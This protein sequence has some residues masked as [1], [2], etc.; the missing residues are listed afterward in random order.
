MSELPVLNTAD[1]PSSSTFWENK[2]QTQATGWDLGNISPP[3]KSFINTLENKNVAILIPGCGNAYEAEYL[4]QKGFT[5]ITLIDIAPSLVETL[6]NKFAHQK[7]ITVLLG[8][9]FEHTGTYNLILEQTFFCA[10]PPE[11][12]QRYAWK[13]HQLLTRKGILAGLLFSRTFEN[14]PPFG[15][16]RLEYEQLFAKLFTFKT[17]KAAENS[18]SNRANT[19]LFFEFEKVDT[20]QVDLFNMDFLTV[21]SKI[22]IEKILATDGIENVSINT[23]NSEILIVSATDPI[24]KKIEDQIDDVF[25]LTLIHKL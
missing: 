19:E 6:Q 15:G 9:F 16:S 7:Q 21:S 17:L 23:K 18:I 13:M 11:M 1:I 8:D 14:G 22:C 20:V 12:R 5:N 25:K 24:G 4:I 2:Y 10:L 3:L